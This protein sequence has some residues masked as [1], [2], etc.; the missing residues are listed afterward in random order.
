[1]RILDCSVAHE[2]LVDMLEHLEQKRLGSSPTD[3]KVR[4]SPVRP[5][6]AAPRWQSW[7]CAEPPAARCSRA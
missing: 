7:A 1:M 6:L 2:N 3:A 4:R 5:L